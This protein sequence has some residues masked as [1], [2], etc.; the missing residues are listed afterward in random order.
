MKKIATKNDVAVLIA[1]ACFILVAFA[2]LLERVALTPLFLGMIAV[3]VYLAF[4]AIYWSLRMKPRQNTEEA[5]VFLR[6]DNTEIW[7]SNLQAPAALCDGEDN[8]VLANAAFLEALGVEKVAAGRPFSAYCRTVPAEYLALPENEENKNKEIVLINDKLFRVGRSSLEEQNLHMLFLEDVTGLFEY[9]RRYVEDRT[10]VAYIVIDNIE[11]LLQYI[12]EKFRSAASEVEEILRNWAA[13]MNGV[14]RSYERDKYI[15]L[16]DYAHLSECVESRFNILDEVR[17]IRVGD[18]MPVTVSIG[19]SCVSGTLSYREQMA[20]AA[21][22]MA[23]QRG[24]DQVVYKNDTGTEFYGGKTKA[25]HKRANVRA[26]VMGNAIVGLMVRAD[27]VL[28]MGHNY[29]DYDSFGASIGM[30]RLAMF[31]GAEPHIVVNRSDENLRSCFD[32]IAACEEY[33]D[34][35]ITESEALEMVRPRTLLI[36]VD[37]NNVSNTVCPKLFGLVEDTVIVDHHTKSGN[38]D[39]KPKISYI[40]PSAS[41]ASEM[42]AEI[43]EQH[44]T[45]KRLLKEE[46]ELLLS[47]ILLDTKQLTKN[48]GTRT[49]GAAQFLRGEGANPSETNELFKTDVNDM[50]KQGRFLS[51]VLVYKDNLAIAVCD[52]DT[53]ASYRVIAAKAADALLAGKGINASFALVPINGRVHVSARSDG[54]VNVAKILEELHGG[55]H[56]DSAGAQV[57]ESTGLATVERL[58]KAIDKYIN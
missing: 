31:A 48:T 11:E 52:G 19:V 10:A 3:F 6:T 25:V 49:Y 23:L 51:H 44:M 53:D 14:I 21:L 24:G 15:M 38:T 45:T 47:G 30:A 37:V 26:R 40:E 50:I 46:A 56:F 34:V 39:V 43:L 22:D 41:S 12:Q 42:V 36:V 1:V 17:S 32:K 27:N 55:G 13:S 4:L 58:K 20:Q 7:I 29:G 9:F 2:I 5:E 57:D 16:F 28:I 35:F 33:D 8:L 18:G 54:T